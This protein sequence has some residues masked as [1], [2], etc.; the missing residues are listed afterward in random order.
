MYLLRL[1]RGNK[2]NFLYLRPGL[3]KNFKDKIK[4]AVEGEHYFTDYQSMCVW[5]EKNWSSGLWK[6]PVVLPGDGQL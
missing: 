4:L 3:K 1:R 5:V 2:S 6:E